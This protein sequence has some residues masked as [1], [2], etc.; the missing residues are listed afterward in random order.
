MLA[1]RHANM[2]A[3]REAG[4]R[5]VELMRSWYV[6]ERNHPVEL[7]DAER[8]RFDTDVVFVGHYEPDQRLQHLEEIVRRGFRLRLFGPTKYWAAPLARS[9]LLRHLAPVQMVWGADYSRALCGARIALCFLSKLNRDT[10]TRR[11]F[12]IPATRTLMLSE[13]S[14][15][16]ASLYQEG[17]EADFFRNRDEMMDKIE[18]YLRD[19]AARIRVAEGGHR[20]VMSDGHDID[21]RMRELLAW[22]A[23]LVPVAKVAA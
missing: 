5:R 2:D 11:C 6:A 7:S 8:A 20:R 21:S 12:E 10:Y 3:F 18:F 13:Y 17:N 23:R 15:D 9:E 22:I 4:A 16:L 19:D 1:Y 14:A